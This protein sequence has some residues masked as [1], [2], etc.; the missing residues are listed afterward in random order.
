MAAAAAL[1]FAIAVSWSPAR[2]AATPSSNAF[3]SSAAL[4]GSAGAAAG[5]QRR[6]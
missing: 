4:A 6:W 5:R 2:L 1:N 3:F